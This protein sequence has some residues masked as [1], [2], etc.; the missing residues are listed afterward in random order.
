MV[1]NLGYDL[2]RRRRK[3]RRRIDRIAPFGMEQ[4]GAAVAGHRG[5]AEARSHHRHI[6]QGKVPSRGLIRRAVSGRVCGG[7]TKGQPG[8]GIKDGGRIAKVL[9]LLRD[10]SANPQEV[11]SQLAFLGFGDRTPFQ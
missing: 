5:I 3:K 2:W 11:L 7:V 1:V 4:N 9:Q 6:I 8:T 10:L